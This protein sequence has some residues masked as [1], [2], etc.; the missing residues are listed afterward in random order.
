M[1]HLENG[2]SLQVKI[3]ILNLKGF[4]RTATAQAIIYTQLLKLNRMD[5]LEVL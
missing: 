3:Y 2:L 5:F 4:A 1:I